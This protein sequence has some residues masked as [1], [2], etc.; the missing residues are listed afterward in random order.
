MCL[1]IYMELIIINNDW[2]LITGEA[3]MVKIEIPQQ[4]NYATY[5]TPLGIHLK[6]LLV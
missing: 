5:T 4:N 6:L 3:N 2:C 1:A